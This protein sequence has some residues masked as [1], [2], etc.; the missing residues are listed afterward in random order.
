VGDA[1]HIVLE[2]RMASI[3]NRREISRRSFYKFGHK[4]S[5]SSVERPSTLTLT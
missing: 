4:N 2:M 3:Y 5:E 1:L